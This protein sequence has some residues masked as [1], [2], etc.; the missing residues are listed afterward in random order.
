[1]ARIKKRNSDNGE[2]KVR[3]KFDLKVLNL[4]IKYT[5][6]EYV[7][8][9]EIGN[10][11]RFI[12]ATDIESYRGN[13]Q[14]YLRLSIILSITKSMIDSELTNI[15]LIKDNIV[16]DFPPAEEV[17]EDIDFSPSGLGSGDCRQ[18]SS[19]VNEKIRYTA[20]YRHREKIISMLSSI[21]DEVD[22]KASQSQLISNI[23]DNMTQLLG[24]LQVSENTDGML[25]EF[26]FSSP[27]AI[28]DIERVHDK[29]RKPS[30]ILYTGMRQFNAIL[31]G[32][33]KAT[34]TYYIVGGSGKFKS[35]T[36]LNIA[37]QIRRFNP[38]IVPYENGRRKCVLFITL[39]N[40]I[41]ETIERLYDM[42]SDIEDDFKEKSKEDVVR[43]LRE[44][45]SFD[46]SDGTGGIDLV[47]LY[48]GDL[49]IKTTDLY[50]IMDSL[51]RKGYEPIC[52]VLDYLKRI[53]SERPHMGIEKVR[54]SNVCKELKNFC[55]RYDIPVISAMQLNRTGNGIIDAA[56][57]DN[58]QDVARFVGPDSIGSAWEIFE[59]A[60]WLCLINPEIQKSTNR[61]FL[62]FS[63]Y[64]YRGRD[65][66]VGTSTYFN[67]PFVNAKNIRLAPDVMLDKPLSIVSLSN[68][69]E[70][71][72]EEETAPK[73]PSINI[74]DKL[75][76][77]R[78][79]K[80]VTSQLRGVSMSNII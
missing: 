30:S 63:R 50:G 3:F 76:D 22:Y 27:T 41:E 17:L 38:Q 66:V 9:S 18:I 69:L 59:D 4:F 53:D 46:F 52:L 75:R 37:D 42:Y 79:P 43:T 51:R 19:F 26:S 32:G 10:L 35:G 61:L 7:S 55:K 15:D 47:F 58:K 28:R 80:S 1:M 39:E 71:L 67:H 8:L 14:I 45:G 20:L 54:L 62:T 29:A 33:F 11:K 70:S 77:K 65:K 73:N 5:Q 44:D 21:D 23:E 13:F 72:V 31:G 36:L 6:S 56:M 74:Q 57:R 25:T 64:K 34:K 68:D 2:Q 16:R 48:F 49:E 40:D 78:N 12:E 24:E 60:D